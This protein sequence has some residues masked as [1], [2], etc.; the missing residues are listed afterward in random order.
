MVERRQLHMHT[1]NFIFLFFLSLPPFFGIWG[2][3][4]Q[5]PQRPPPPWLRAWTLPKSKHP[6]PSSKFSTRDSWVNVLFDPACRAPGEWSIVHHLGTS[7]SPCWLWIRSP[8][9]YFF[10]R[11]VQGYHSC[12]AI[13]Y[14]F[15]I[16]TLMSEKTWIYWRNKP[17]PHL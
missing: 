8:R 7:V 9:R 5:P 14:F 17:Q 2:G 12:Y 4:G 3:G 13:D 6:R 1:H 16:S 11:R 15:C 10:P